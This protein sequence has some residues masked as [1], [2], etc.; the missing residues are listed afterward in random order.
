MKWTTN[1]PSE[2]GWYWLYEAGSTKLEF[3][4]QRPGHAYLCIQIEPTG[5]SMKR[6]FKAVARMRTAIWS[7]PFELPVPD[8]LL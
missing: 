3:V 2:Q 6:E 8:T 4:S 1:P 5:H 7:G